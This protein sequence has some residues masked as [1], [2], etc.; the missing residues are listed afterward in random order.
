MFIYSIYSIYMFSSS[1]S[2][3]WCM[4]ECTAG[5][6]LSCVGLAQV[7]TPPPSRHP[8]P[9]PSHVVA[10]GHNTHTQT[11]TQHPHTTHTQH[12]HTT[13]T[14][15][16]HPQHPHTTPTHTT[17]THNTHTHNSHT[18]HSQRSHSL[19]NC[20]LDPESVETKLFETWNRSRNY[21]FN[22]YFNKYEWCPALVKVEAKLYKKF[23][24][25]IQCH[26]R[27]EPNKSLEMCWFRQAVVSGSTPACLTGEKLFK[28][29]SCTW[30]IS[31]KKAKPIWW[32]SSPPSC[33]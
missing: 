6:Y 19:L 16:T 2:C 4:C 22:K 32:G 7:V 10:G 24:F 21:L 28:L 12:P 13:H 23:S 1:F 29:Y 18:Q 33:Q 9:P 8:L 20:F 3:D 5:N 15:N 26:G 27:N 31:R 17:P 30:F 11:H 25:S 14:H